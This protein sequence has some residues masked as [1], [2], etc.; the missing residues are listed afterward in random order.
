V[1]DLFSD[2]HSD[3]DSKSNSSSE[4]NLGATPLSGGLR[5]TF[6]VRIWS[7][8]GADMLRGHVQHVRSRK[9]AY[10]ATRERL[11]RFIQDHSQDS[12]GNPCRS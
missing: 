8:D 4:P 3:S 10:F 6:V 7:T 11:V 2:S 12:D 5:D 1:S 9:R